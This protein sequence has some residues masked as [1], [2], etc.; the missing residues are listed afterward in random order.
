[1]C[2]ADAA[3]WDK[4]H[5]VHCGIDPVRYDT[6]PHT[7]QTLLFVGRLAGVKGVPILLDAVATL[8]ARHPQLR[9]ALI[10]DGP[11][12]AAL[13]ERAKP[14][15]ETVVFLG[16]QGQSEVAEALSQSDVFVLPSFAE[17]VPVVLMEAMAAGVPVVATQIA[18]IPE[19][20]TQWENGVLV[21]PGDAPAL[22]QAIEQLLA[23][24][25]QRRVMGAVGRATVEAEFNIHIEAARL[26]HLFTA[27][28]EGDSPAKR[29]VME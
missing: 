2:F 17:G 16:Y 26:S 18:G 3:H 7:G 29:E 23:S 20:V 9:L 6:A 19:L 1:M 28:A 4:L 13:E 27:Y 10:G 24:P 21:P 8:K 25:D 14:L 11:E 12:R 15:G 22:A 5:I